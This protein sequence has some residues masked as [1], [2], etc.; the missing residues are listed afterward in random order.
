MSEIPLFQSTLPQGERHIPQ[1]ILR[2]T[3]LFQST[4][5]QGER[6]QQDTFVKRQD[7]FNPRSHKGSDSNK[8]HLLNDRIISIHAPTR[9]ATTVEHFVKLSYKF[10]STLPQGERHWSRYLSNGDVD[11]NPRSH[12]GSDRIISVL[13]FRSENFNPRSHK[14]SDIVYSSNGGSAYISIHAPTRGATYARRSVS[15]GDIYFN[16]RSHKG[17][18]PMSLCAC[19]L[20]TISIHAPTRGATKQ[21]VNIQRDEIISIHAPTRGATIP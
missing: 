19:L 20:K 1:G 9:G 13:V 6:Q 17:S 7:Y 11:F 14:G 10:Q 15:Y 21:Y 8:T 16:P 5:P 4:L 12:K 2:R 18:D 3:V